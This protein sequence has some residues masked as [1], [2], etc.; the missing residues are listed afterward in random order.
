MTLHMGFFDISE[1]TPGSLLTKLSTDS[2]K[3]NGVAL[4]II[5]VIVQTSVM[6][7]IGITLGFYYDWRITLIYL[8]FFPLI[9][10]NSMMRFKTEKGF[11]TS[12]QKIEIEAG[13]ILSES[14]VNTK[15]IFSYNMQDKVVDLYRKTLEQK[16]RNLLSSSLVSG[17]LFGLSQFFFYMIYATLFYS[18]GQFMLNGGLS[19]KNM[20]NAIFSILFSAFG[21]GQAQQYIKDYSESKLA[22]VSLCK[23]LDEKT[24]IDPY[25]NK[26][27]SEDFKDFEGSIEFKNV[28]F[29]YP[30][31]SNQIVLHNLSFT[32]P[33]GHSVAFVGSSG[34][35]KSTII[36]LLERFY[37]VS[38]GE[39]LIGG[40]NIKE[41]D[42]IQYRKRVGLV[43]QEPVL[44]K[45]SL[46][47]NI[48]YGKLDASEEEIRESAKKAYIVDLVL[49]SENNALPVSGGEK[50]RI[51]I[52][53][54]IIKNPK[55]LLL[56][57][58][59][60]ALDKNSEE[61]VQKALDETK[62]GRTSIIIA[63]KYDNI[64]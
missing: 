20:L 31:R 50:Q 34:C 48:R 21:M 29:C 56:D 22:L 23:V 36:Q 14:V 57:E 40:K 37:D 27:K 18:G 43:M 2:T 7:I 25:E 3:V 10:F 1:H 63:H 47:E 30:T 5:G 15:T 6:M 33:N 16:N 41:Y 60:S 28:K 19:L 54:A 45:T 58:A 13:A 11:S 4:A 24:L 46:E 12:D 42:L 49:S 52:A 62:I 39:I 17:V 35:G 64:I 8:G 26:D 55:I 38:A 32:I 53:R 9:V 59:T 51:A 44:F 61:I